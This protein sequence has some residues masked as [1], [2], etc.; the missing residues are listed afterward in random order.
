MAYQKE[1]RIRKPLFEKPQIERTMH[2]MIIPE[3]CKGTSCKICVE[4]CKQNVLELSTEEFNQSGNYFVKVIAD[5]NCDECLNCFRHCPEF[6]I[7]LKPIS[8][9]EVKESENDNP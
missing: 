4:F 7:F 3:L 8:G 5:E 1:K 2:I 9:I 6:A